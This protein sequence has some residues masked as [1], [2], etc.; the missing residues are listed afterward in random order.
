MII[1]Y[2]GVGKWTVKRGWADWTIATN[3]EGL[4]LLYRE[5]SL[6]DVCDTFEMCK[7][8]IEAEDI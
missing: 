8:V 6:V 4:F 2:L 5:K 7:A 1:D 3:A